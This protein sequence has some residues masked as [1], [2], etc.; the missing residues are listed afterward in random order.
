[1]LLPLTLIQEDGRG[2]ERRPKVSR[3]A[4][5]MGESKEAN[6]QH[7]LVTFLFPSVS[8]GEWGSVVVCLLVSS[9]RIPKCNT[10]CDIVTLSSPGKAGDFFFFRTFESQCFQK[11][12]GGAF[13]ESSVLLRPAAA[14]DL[15]TWLS[16]RTGFLV[17]S[18]GQK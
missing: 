2:E 12:H 7:E 5:D 4:S 6:E 16:P 8:R 1:M 9:K 17:Q 15:R 13:V 10:L 14:S 11:R 18:E 3:G